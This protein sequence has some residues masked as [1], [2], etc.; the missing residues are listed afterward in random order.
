MGRLTRDG[1]TE[2]VSR[3][4]ILKR[5]RGQGNIIFPCSAD[6]EQDWQP[7]PVDSYSCYMCDHTYLHTYNIRRDLPKIL[8]FVTATNYLL[9]SSATRGNIQGSMSYTIIFSSHTL[10]VPHMSTAGINSGCGKRESHINWFLMLP[11]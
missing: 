3:D 1:T 10:F 11:D 8:T 9:I 5:E 6:H 7:Y 4:L 2:P